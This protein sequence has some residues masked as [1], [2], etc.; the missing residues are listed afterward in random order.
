M[1]IR[2]RAHLIKI[3]AKANGEEDEVKVDEDKEDKEVVMEILDVVEGQEVVDLVEA[4]VDAI[5]AV[6]A[7][8]LWCVI[9]AGCVA[10]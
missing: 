3:R 1:E 7:M 6:V 4:E 2:Q 10:I 5:P 9:G 8:T